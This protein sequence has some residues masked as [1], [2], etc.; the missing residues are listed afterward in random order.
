MSH[1]R[2]WTVAVACV[3]GVLAAP[4]VAA[5]AA[6]GAD[7]GRIAWSRFVSKAFTGVHIVTARADGSDVRELTRPPRG[8]Q[9]IDPKWS[10]DRRRILLERDLPSGA[11]QIVVIDATGAHQRVIDTG[12]VDPCAAD[13][14]P[15]WSPDGRRIVFTRVVGPFD[16][17]NESARSAV[18]WTARL[19]GRDV[20]R[21]SEPGIDGV[22]EDYEAHWT[23]DG[24]A[25]Q[26]LR[27]RNEPFNS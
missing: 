18:L 2:S 14:A 5:Q 1:H 13:V 16:R 4:V 20:R 23:P 12:C 6:S 9:D 22:Y 24:S 17:P 25:I 8:V 10:P 21:L 11:S 26:F 19:D 27:I 7:S 3:V 15:D